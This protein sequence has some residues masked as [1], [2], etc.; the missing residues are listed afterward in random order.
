[1]AY[2]KP[3]LRNNKQQPPSFNILFP[4]L[5]P[6]RRRTIFDHCINFINMT[7]CSRFCIFLIF[8]Q[9]KILWWFT[10]FVTLP[11]IIFP[12]RYFVNFIFWNL[13]K[14]HASFIPIN[15]NNWYEREGQG[16]YK[17]PSLFVLLIVSINLN[18][19]T[20][21]IS[22]LDSFKILTKCNFCY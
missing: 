5:F 7:N 2:H 4:L 14:Y 3:L 22:F 17:R 8:F 6:L 12:F 19:T 18:Y 20:E 13:L 15:S 10:V 11:Q 21:F 1:M 16:P 9:N